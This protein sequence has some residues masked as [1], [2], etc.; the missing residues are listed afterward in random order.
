[1]VMDGVH[2][3]VTSSGSIL[4]TI[5][6]QDSPHSLTSFMLIGMHRG[7]TSLSVVNISVSDYISIYIIIVT[8]TTIITSSTTRESQPVGVLIITEVIETSP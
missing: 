2:D 6:E 5:S 4:S 1:M 7:L 3:L 8:T